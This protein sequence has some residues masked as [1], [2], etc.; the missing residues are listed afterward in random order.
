MFEVFGKAE[1]K[2]LDKQK[3]DI[4]NSIVDV[5]LA[6]DELNF[7]AKRSLKEELTRL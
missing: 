6:R 5:S 2:H 7:S 3:G 1:I 4:K